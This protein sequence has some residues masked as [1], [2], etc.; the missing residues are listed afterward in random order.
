R[1]ARVRREIRGHDTRQR[2]Y[3]P[4]L[5][6]ARHV[7]EVN[8]GLQAHRRVGIADRS[9]YEETRVDRSSSE[10]RVEALEVDDSAID[11]PARVVDRELETNV[12][13]AERKIRI[14]KRAIVDSRANG[15]GRE[16][17]RA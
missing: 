13:H 9:S 15:Q 14:S 10:H 17:L 3:A 5:E 1:H 2:A 6:R 4:E 12:R 8:D 7:R 11:V 16:L